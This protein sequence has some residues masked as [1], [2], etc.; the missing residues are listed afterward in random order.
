VPGDVLNNIGV[1]N[2]RNDKHGSASVWVLER[3]GFVN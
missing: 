3:I 2:Q 1:V